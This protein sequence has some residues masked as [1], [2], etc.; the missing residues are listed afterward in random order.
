MDNLTQR[1][2]V[3][4]RAAEMFAEF[5][6]KSIR[7]DDIAKDLV[8]SKRTLYELFADKR[9]LLY[10]SVKHMNAEVSKRLMEHIDIERD[11]IPALF[12]IFDVMMNN[13]Q[14]LQRFNDNLSKFYP[15]VF[16]RTMIE[17]RDEGLLH[18]HKI[19]LR[20]IEKGLV[21]PHVNVDLSVTMFYY[22]AQGLVRRKEQLL[23]PEGISEQIAFG[24]TIIIFFR[25]IAT[26][27]GMRH[28]D[29]WIA[30]NPPLS[31]RIAMNK[32]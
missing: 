32:F 3:I 8:M 23:L 26:V 17:G 11:G 10:H 14:R 5:G 19:L 28:I 2:R 30:E 21:S 1:E 4:A 22:T 29:K 6:V 27:E 7:M 18:L 15:E 24:Y 20:F 9:E 25:G 13:S 31:S 12:K 16:K